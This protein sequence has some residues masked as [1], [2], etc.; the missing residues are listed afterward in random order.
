M[1]GCLCDL[2]G[3]QNFSWKDLDE[4]QK[5]ETDPIVKEVRGRHTYKELNLGEAEVRA[6]K[7]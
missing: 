7:Q 4:G 3:G 6:Y 2:K 5:R 1:D